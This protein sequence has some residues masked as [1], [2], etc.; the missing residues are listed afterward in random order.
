MNS[1]SIA[2]AQEASN[3]LKPS[4]IRA[5]VR[6]MRRTHFLRYSLKSCRQLRG[7]FPGLDDF[8]RPPDIA[9]SVMIQ[10]SYFA[11]PEATHRAV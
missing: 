4:N 2:T 7:L 9:R 3:A 5:K 6:V 1:G 8:R 11:V 10:I